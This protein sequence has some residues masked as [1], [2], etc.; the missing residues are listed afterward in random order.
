MSVCQVRQSYHHVEFLQQRLS[1]RGQAISRVV[2][3]A[4]CLALCGMLFWE[5]FRLARNSWDFG[6]CGGDDS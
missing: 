5:L 6:G 3:D 1:R 2:F 4:I